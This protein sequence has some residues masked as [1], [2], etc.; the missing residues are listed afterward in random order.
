MMSNV[1]FLALFTLFLPAL[2]I[3]CL[4]IYGMRVAGRM[5]KRADQRLELDR[6][7]LSSQQKQIDMLRQTEERLAKVEK[8]L[9]DVQE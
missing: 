4:V 6:K 2:I 8:K 5:N 7:S 9:I 1:N 3:L